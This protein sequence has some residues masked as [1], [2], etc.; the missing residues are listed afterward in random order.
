M[1][2][3]YLESPST[4]PRFNLA[5]EQY[6]FDELP[7]D[8][9]Y[10]MLWQ[11]E[12]AII[13]GKH[14]NTIEEINLEYVKSQKIQV[15]RRL[16]GGGAVYHDLGNLNFTFI[17]DAGEVEDLDL[18]FFSTPIVKALKKLG[19]E[20]EQN[21][22]NDI[23]IDGRKFSGSAQYIKEGR[24]M[25]H[26]TILFNS[27]L[28]KIAAALAVSKDKVE[29]KGVKSVKSRVTNLIDY[30]PKK[31]SLEE[32]KELLKTYVFEQ[33]DEQYYLTEADLQRILEIKKERYD[34]WEWNY[35][36]SPKYSITKERY[37]PNCGKIQ[38][39]MEVDKGTI[40]KFATSGDYFGM[41]AQEELENLLV[42]K[43]LEE[44]ELKD[45]LRG[46]KM[47]HFYKNLSLPEFLDLKLFTDG[48]KELV[49]FIHEVTIIPGEFEMEALAAGITRVLRGEEK[50]RVYTE[51][52]ED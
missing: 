12:N 24:I 16:S 46:I 20:V 3:V 42:G 38:L 36:H 10:F 30:L 2:I 41:G 52:M 17:L 39:N 5:L 34:T 4:D 14:Q 21:G 48:V 43:K 45:A 47:D 44:K 31:I 51:K 32:F 28:N 1:S 9:E 6:V 7:R 27:D 49:E 29:S 11:N 37:F 19:L 22:R 26:G 15:V 23:T 35:G 25:H 50:A 33:I 8:K 13:V 40:M 18:S